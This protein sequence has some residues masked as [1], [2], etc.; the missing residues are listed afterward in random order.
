MTG[1]LPKDDP[2]VDE[3]NYIFKEFNGASTAFI[4]IE[5]EL[6]EMIR[7]ADNITPKIKTLKTWIEA[8]SSKKVKDQH[9]TLLDKVKNGKAE[10]S[11]E[12]FRRVDYK[13]MELC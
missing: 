2:M 9:Q 3:F 8:N 1:L 12:Y 4:V 5:G 6:D 7:Y 11:G 13:I 10:F